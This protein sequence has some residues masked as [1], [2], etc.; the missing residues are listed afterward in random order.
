MVWARS[1]LMI[2]DDLLRPIPV[3]WIKFEGPN[4]EK[5]YKEIYNL[6]LLSFRISEHSIQEKEFHWSKGQHEKFKVVWEINKDLDKFSYYYVEIEFKGESHGKHGKASIGVEG[7]LRTEYPQDTFWQ[8][9]LL[10]EFLR[11]FWH[12]IFYSSKREEY[13]REGRR[14]ISLFVDQLKVLTRV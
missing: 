12:T 4:P 1:K 11:M 14:I 6:A 5:F 2:E 9:S 3:V 13:A 7:I 10:Y 8:K